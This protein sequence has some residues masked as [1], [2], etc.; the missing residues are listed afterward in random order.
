[1]SKKKHAYSIGIDYGTNSARALVV[2]V[3]DGK[4]AGNAVVSYPSGKEGIL[5]DKKDHNLARQSPADYVLCLEAAI[6][7][8]LLTARKN[9]GLKNEEIIGLGVDTTGSTP[10]PVRED[11]QPLA[12][13]KKFKNNLNAQAWLWKDHTSFEEAR[14]IT[15][16]AAEM[17]PHYLKKCGGTYS[18][19]WFW[20]KILHCLRV[21]PDVFDAAYTWIECQDFIPALLCGIKRP[22]D[23]VRGICAAGHKAM[24]NESWGG[25]PDNDFLSAL[26]P[27]LAR[28]RKPL[29][30][31]ALPINNKAGTL[32]EEWAK[33]LELKAGIPV[34][35]GAFDA[36]LGGVGA[37]ISKGTLVKI[38]GTSTCDIMVAPLSDKLA[39]IP[40]V[41]GIVEES[42]LP[43]YYG[44]EAG[45]SA[46]GDIFRWFVRE[47]C[48]SDDTLQVAL[49]KEAARLK[50]GETGL[51]A[52]DWNNGNRTILVDPNLTGL[53]VGMTLHTNRAHIYRTLIEATAFGALTIINRLEEYNVK[54]EKIV[55]C[56]GIAEKNSLFMQIYADVL[57]RP[58]LISRSAQTCALGA[59]IAGAVVGGAYKNCEAAIDAMTGV[60]KQIYNPISE[61]VA[62]YKELYK[63]YRELHDAFGIKGVRSYDFGMIMKKLLAIKNLLK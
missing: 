55:C 35:V 19:E 61:N 2:D 24:Y 30:S 1:M 37:G 41:C 58:M 26:D 25:L 52:L 13:N 31:K 63:I 11:A 6:K 29:Q 47:V 27:R 38:I 28:V 15:E 16:K 9:V 5:L 22:E 51:I 3:A 17:R 20:A 62:V 14:L 60:K 46:V 49:T 57:N 39:D 7:K 43:G 8:A 59:A 21:A 34:A 53:I 12:F 54:I 10:M 23:I 36:H 50:P 42:V 40:G 32:C 56:G 44:I 4:E 33:K 48:N 18:S 45:Q